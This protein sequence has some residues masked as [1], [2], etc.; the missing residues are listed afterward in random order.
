[1]ATSL[2]TTLVP[3]ALELVTEYGQDAVFEVPATKTYDA[4]TGLTAE[5]SPTD[6]TKK[7]TPP[8]PYDKRWIDGDLIQVDDVRVYLPASGL[9]FTPTR[10]YKVTLASSD[11]FRIIRVVPIYTGESIALY[12]IGLRG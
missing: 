12:E 11:V 7:V 9:T 6:H 2:D 3:R 5:T 1:M 8:E 4:T 10:G